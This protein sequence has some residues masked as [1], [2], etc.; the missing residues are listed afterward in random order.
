MTSYQKWQQMCLA[1]EILF[2]VSVMCLHLPLY[3]KNN[4]TKYM[5]LPQAGYPKYCV[6]N[7]SLK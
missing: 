6:A 5:Y 3:I 4:K 2:Y 7:M 1:N